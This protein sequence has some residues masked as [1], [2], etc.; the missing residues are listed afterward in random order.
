MRIIY[1]GTLDNTFSFYTGS[2]DWHHEVFVLPTCPQKKNASLVPWD[3]LS[4]SDQTFLR[5]EYPDAG[6]GQFATLCVRSA[7][8]SAFFSHLIISPPIIGFWVVGAFSS[9]SCVWCGHVFGHRVSG[10]WGC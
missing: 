3:S 5:D 8:P 9:S 10:I 7:R 1:F 4:P 2:S 6:R